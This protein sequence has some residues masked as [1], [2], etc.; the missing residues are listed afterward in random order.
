MP[1][2]KMC[3]GAIAALAVLK[4]LGFSRASV[5]RPTARQRAAVK[6]RCRVVV[7]SAIDDQEQM[8]LLTYRVASAIGLMSEQSSRGN[9]GALIAL[10]L[11]MRAEGRPP[12]SLEELLRRLSL[13]FLRSV[14][15]DDETVRCINDADAMTA[16]MR[17]KSFPL[18]A[19][20]V[21]T[22]ALFS[23]PSRG[24]FTYLSTID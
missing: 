11:A 15:G 7:I 16:Y 18:R 10:D 8:H 5:Q 24:R 22:T 2:K 23:L 13:L 17:V 12:K 14:Y 3:L 6:D 1:M 4:G 20:S 21:D 19:P 9:D